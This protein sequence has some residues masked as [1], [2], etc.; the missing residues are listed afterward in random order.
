MCVSLSIKSLT[1]FSKNSQLLFIGHRCLLSST[2]QELYRSSDNTHHQKGIHKTCFVPLVLQYWRW[3]CKIP[4]RTFKI[5]S[6]TAP[7]YQT[8]FSK[9]IPQW[10]RCDLST[11]KCIKKNL[12]EHQFPGCGIRCKMML[13]LSQINKHSVGFLKP[14]YS[15][16]SIYNICSMWAIKSG[17]PVFGVKRLRATNKN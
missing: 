17:H 10:V 1:C 3:P 16:E 4:F 5:P 12:S 15:N 13:N 2:N 14:T 11:E 6:E 9:G 7:L 8:L